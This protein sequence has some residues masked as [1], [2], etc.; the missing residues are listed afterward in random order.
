M[1]KFV[2]V[3]F[4]LFFVNAGHSQNHS[5]IPA[6]TSYALGSG[7]V[8]FTDLVRIHDS[9]LTDKNKAIIIKYF[10][11]TLKVNA[12]FVNENAVFYFTPEVK[13][14]VDFYSIDI[15]DVV[16]IDYSSTSSLRYAFTTLSQI[17]TLEG[18]QKVLPGC[19]ITDSPKFAY[20]GMHLDVS[21]HFFTVEEVKKYLDGMAR[22]KFNNFHWHLTDDQGW[23][24]EIKKYPLLTE[25]GGKRSETLIGHASGSP[26]KY[27]GKKHEG[28]YTQEDIREVVN[29]ASQLGINVIPE[30]E[31]PGHAS[32]ALRAYPQFSCEG[33]KVSEVNNW[34]VFETIFCSKPETIEFLKDVLEELVPLFPSPYYHIGGDEVPI[35]SWKSCEKCQNLLK[36]KD[37]KNE[38]EIEGYM[39]R[40]VQRFLTTKGKRI[41]GW[42]EILEGGIEGDAIVMSWRGT[43]GGE[44]AAKMKHQVIMTPNSSCYF[45]HYQSDR[46]NETLSIGGYTP[47]DEVYEFNPIPD[48]MAEDL[49]AYVIGG[50]ANLWTEYIKDYKG[51][52]EKIYPRMLALSEALWS[53]NKPGYN[54]FLV[55]LRDFHLPLLDKKGVN[56]SKALNQSSLVISSREGGVDLNIAAS[57]LGYRIKA[58][59]KG[60]VLSALSTLSLPIYSEQEERTREIEVE[61]LNAEEKR[62]DFFKKTILVHPLLGKT[63]EISP[64]PNANYMGGGT[65]TLTDGNKG[66]RPWNG[67]EWLGFRESEVQLSITNKEVLLIKEVKMGFLNAPSSWIYLPEKVEISYSKNGRKWR[68]KTFEVS[69]ENEVF[70]LG[71]KAK[72]ISLTVIAKDKIPLGMQGA[73]SIPWLFIDEVY[74]TW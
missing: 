14:E 42:D 20:R 68:T 66:Q 31:L 25:I 61:T 37:F 33:E 2:F 16:R 30:I 12:V 74:F 71:E 39:I 32:A 57:D 44:E 51:V 1:I 26:E 35:S 36:E 5:I 7:K 22:Y 59:D 41:I 34:G 23:R 69:K 48:G 72:F 3:L 15:K 67:K 18:N 8:V 49:H 53:I 73:G 52:E 70:E 63:W 19:L 40:E 56:Y 9:G 24:V 21:R 6:P 50:Q 62:V 43:K 13:N 29:Y 64:Q 10:T 11:Q 28:F 38:L 46:S 65:L 54:D 27:D 47:L 55:R 17:L 60:V 58:K 4:A 45:D